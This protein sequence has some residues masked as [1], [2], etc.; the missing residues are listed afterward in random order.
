MSSRVLSIPY[1]DDEELEIRSFIRAQEISRWASS[2]WYLDAGITGHD[3]I[4]G[5]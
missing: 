2:M 1:V 4:Y 3:W 5:K